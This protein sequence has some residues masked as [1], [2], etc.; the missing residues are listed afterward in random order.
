MVPSNLLSSPGLRRALL[1][2]VGLLLV[3]NPVLLDPL[4]VGTPTYEY[5]A[6]DATAT[7]D[8]IE[9]ARR[10]P[11]EVVGVRGFDCYLG[12]TTRA[13]VLDSALRDREPYTVT[14]RDAGP[15]GAEPYVRLNGT[16]YRRQTD[17]ETLETGDRRVTVSLTRISPQEALDG[18]SVDV[19]GGALSERGRRAVATGRLRTDEPLPYESAL[20]PNTYEPAGRFVRT[21]DGYVLL[22]LER[23][24]P[25][26]ANRR[27]YSGLGVFVGLVAFRLGVLPGTDQL[28]E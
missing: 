6:V 10:P 28:A 3:A 27:L 24:Q 22:G 1:L 11:E 20:G 12:P 7:P 8:G 4:G 15:V 5:R 14:L 25:G 26:L 21:D 16:F 9:L 17:Q 23:Y 19:A 2:A 13:C 18:A